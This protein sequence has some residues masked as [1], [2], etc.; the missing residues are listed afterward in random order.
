VSRVTANGD[1][2]QRASPTF[3]PGA[4]TVQSVYPPA[5]SPL[6]IRQQTAVLSLLQVGGS[7]G[8]G[9]AVVRRAAVDSDDRTVSDEATI[10]VDSTHNLRDT[11][12]LAAG[13]TILEQSVQRWSWRERHPEH[14]G[15]GGVRKFASC[16]TTRWQESQRRVRI[17][18]SSAS[19]KRRV[20]HRT[21]KIF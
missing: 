15:V 13:E 8:E 12:S 6:I 20:L 21:K 1:T 5:P 11:V 9:E 14:V 19:L 10:Y 7:Y 4:G 2:Y 16:G 18:E 17:R 3:D